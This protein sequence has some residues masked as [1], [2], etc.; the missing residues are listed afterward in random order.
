MFENIEKRIDEKMSKH[1]TLHVGGNARWF[2]LPKNEEELISAIHE[3]KI[4]GI[5][6]F[7]LGCGSNLLVSDGGYDGAVIS[8]EKLK[9]IEICGENEIM[10]GAGVSLFEL[11]NF[12][13]KN[14]YG[15]LEFSF[16]IPGSVGGACKMNAGAFGGEFCKHIKNIKIFDEIRLKNRKKLNFSYRKGCLRKNEV[17]ISAT[18]KLEKCS[19]KEILSKQI[20][21]LNKRRNSQPYGEF[22]L[23][24]VFKRGKIIPAQFIDGLG[25]KGYKI[26]GAEVSKKHAGF[27]INNKNATAEDF[28][29]IVKH[30]ENEAKKRKIKLEREFF[31]LE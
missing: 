1:T 2:L 7:I 28:L 5:D 17:L 3:C 18:L 9:K 19:P 15:G 24:S 31:Y 16:G 20:E 11:N 26:G 27:I 14:G 22:S 23:G 8:T 4:C 12:C 13:Q 29:N 25:L 6:F 10:A 21:Y 30:I